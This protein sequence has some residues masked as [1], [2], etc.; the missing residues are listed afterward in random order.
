MKNKS[1]FVKDIISGGLN[2]IDEIFA[3]DNIQKHTTRTGNPYVR[4][5]LRDKTGSINARIWQ[6][7]FPYCSID[8]IAPGDV[9][10]VTFYTEEYKDQTQVIITKLAKT[11]DYD[12]SDLISSSTKNEHEMLKRLKEYINLVKDP[13]LKALLNNI[14]EDDKILKKFKVSPAGVSVHHA[15]MGGLLEHTLEVVDLA[16]NIQKHYS[17]ANRDL[18]IAGAL[19]HDIGKIYELKF[20]K[21]GFVYTKEG[22][23]IGHIVIAVGMVNKFWPKEGNNDLRIQLLHIILSHHTELEFGAVVKPATLEAGIVA[24]ADLTSSRTRLF[25]E[26]IEKNKHDEQGFSEYHK[27]L[28]TRLYIPESI[29]G[30]LSTEDNSKDERIED[31]EDM[32]NK[33][34]KSKQDTEFQGKLI[35]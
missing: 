19:L 20:D 5:T 18:I 21:T 15:F 8:S 12:L 1:V 22:S 24:L 35:N 28:G 27:Y 2:V 3:V 6:D 14:F 7:Y 9:V 32:K 25:F 26:E 13:D 23:L 16:L 30:I 4:L 29:N 10:K 33:N 11:D 34:Q 31:P 17:I